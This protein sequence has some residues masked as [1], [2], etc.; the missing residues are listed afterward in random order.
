MLAGTAPLWLIGLATLLIKGRDTPAASLASL[1]AVFSFD[2]LSLVL[3]AYWLN[4]KTLFWPTQLGI[5]YEWILAVGVPPSQLV[6]GGLSIGLTLLLVWRLRRQRVLA[7][8]L[9]WFGIALAPTA[10]VIPHHI[11]RA[12]RFLYLPLVGLSILLAGSL[13]NCKGPASRHCGEERSRSY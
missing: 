4:I 9:L 3:A 10:Q 11:A 13:R 6:L 8:G 7:F 5:L 1:P 2:W 12:D